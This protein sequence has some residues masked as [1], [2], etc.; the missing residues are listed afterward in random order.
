MKDNNI[1]KIIRTAIKNTSF[2]DNVFIAGGFVR[3]HIMGRPSKD[4]DLLVSGHGLSG[5]IDLA[6]FLKRV[7]RGTW[8]VSNPVTF[9]K[10][11]TAQI[12]IDQQDVEIVAARKETYDMVSRNPAVEPGTVTDDVMRRDFTINSMLYNISQDKIVD[13]LCGAEDIKNRIIRTTSNPDIIFGEDPLRIMRAIR[14]SAQLGFDIETRTLVSVRNSVAKLDS[15]SNERI[16][17]EFCKIL[18][19]EHFLDGMELLKA[20][21]ILTHICPQFKDL[22]LVKNQGKYHIKS[23]WNHTLEVMSNSEPTVIA[24]MAALF[25]DIGKGKTMT[26]SENG[27]VHF[28]GHQFVSARIAVNFMKLF[29]FKTEEIEWVQ[30]AIE[31]HMNFIDGMLPKTIR[32]ITNTIGK[33][34]FLFAIDLAAAD[35]KRRERISIVNN[36]REF[37]LTDDFVP[38]VQMKMPV[39]GDVIMSR[40]NLKPSKRVGDLLQIEKDYLFEYPEATE[41]EILSIL[42]QEMSINGKVEIHQYV[43]PQK[44]AEFITVHFSINKE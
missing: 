6:F 32:K 41:Y 44:P 3:D 11:G 25:H 31:L 37:V 28:F 20:T 35:S 39:N 24:R 22:F 27:D 2:E 1:I 42:D 29:K 14:F 4:I 13:L 5:G 16:R 21:G 36:V 40:Y 38:E 23:A 12:I 18:V 19:S 7:L 9:P 17:D 30:T 26:I 8:D 33:D 15:I 34:K 43:K 10:F